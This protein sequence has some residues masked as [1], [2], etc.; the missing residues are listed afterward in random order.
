M[1]GTDTPQL[2]NVAG[3]SLMREIRLMADAGLPPMA[4]LAAGT[5]NVAEYA[6]TDLGDD[7][8]FGVVAPGNRADLVLLRGNPLEDIAN[9]E[10][11][12][13]VMVRGRWVP[14]E[15]IERGLARIAAKY[16]R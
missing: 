5:R 2:F 4:I 7:G 13:G 8:R 11:R 15:E 10:R 9:V 14:A 16:G 3:F 1:M 6:R 12:A